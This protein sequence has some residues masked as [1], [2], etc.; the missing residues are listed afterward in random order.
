MS[1]SDATLQRIDAILGR[2]EAHFDRI[3][4]LLH[5][6]L[7]RL[8]GRHQDVPPHQRGFGVMGDTKDGT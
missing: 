7:D 5:E 1:E 8:D 4:G 6:I 3:D 2:M